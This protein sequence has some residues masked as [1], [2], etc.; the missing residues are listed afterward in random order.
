MGR[1]YQFGGFRVYVDRRSLLRGNEPVQVAA[2]AFDVLVALIDQ[3]HRVVDKDELI[4]R[5]WPDQIVEEANLTQQIF[6]LRRLL[7]HGSFITTVP[8]RGYQFTMA[9]DEW[10]EA[11]SRP[12]GSVAPL[13]RLDLVL[14]PPL[15]LGLNP[16]LVLSR[17]GHVLVYVGA[18]A[19]GTGLHV[20]RLDQH[21]SRPVAGTDGASAPFL[22]PDG[23]WVGYSGEGH[24]HRISIDG[25]RA[26]TICDV[27]GE[28][29]GATWGP[30]NAIVFA[31]APAGPL[32]V[33]AAAGGTARPLTR[34][35]YE[36]G[37][38]SHRFPSFAPDGR[39]VLF[40]IARAGDASFDDATLAIASL[41]SGEHRAVLA[42]GSC[43]TVSGESVLRFQRGGM[44]FRAPFDV[45]A[46]Q[47]LASPEPGEPIA[48]H[49]AGAAHV[50]IADSGL[51]VFAPPA[52]DTS[53]P[54]LIWRIDE[55]EAIALD[56]LA[57][58]P[59]EP[60]V[61]P[62]GSRLV[63]GIR[64]GQSDLWLFDIRRKTLSRLTESGDNFAA[65]WSPDGRSIVFSSNRRG[66]SNL[67]GLAVGSPDPP[68]LLVEDACEL[69]PGA[70][71]PDGRT[72]VYTAYDPHTGADIWA[73]RD[74]QAEVLIK[75]RFNV[76][77]PALS[78]DGRWLAYTSDA[79]GDS[80]VYMIR[81]P[82]LTDRQQVSTGGASE[83]VWDR[84]APRLF[85]RTRT[86]LAYVE[87][88]SDGP[89]RPPLDL[90]ADQ[91]V[92]GSL[93]GLPNYDVHPDGRLLFV[94]PAERPMTRA[95]VR[96]VVPPGPGA[97]DRET[98]SP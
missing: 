2:R 80:E 82:Q 96:V 85:F 72:L 45:D 34:L 89:A 55:G 61:S 67:Y 56:D 63:L 43:G 75:S 7:G 90:I 73:L 66:P 46:V 11:P 21:A 69:V 12:V 10:V 15:V 22:S 93:T 71:T 78:P 49:D 27:E 40:T 30:D 60:R 19:A 6:V 3:R 74:G 97:R 47:C 32:Y 98:R 95:L 41:H 77:S 35:A 86:N 9:V 94:A 57:G 36:D 50:A 31:P 68:V 83:P 4:G 48:I 54:R 58:T 24:L 52:A 8:R 59:E 76:F 26:L 39:S 17:D 87:L 13:L 70:W 29:R 51:L 38:R 1:V 18:S 33:V 91:F 5:V 37:E 79:S 88:G 53:R 42:R 16:A 65:I 44:L 92:R 64:V 28:G 25:G 20:R 14:D 23:R 84:S 62:D 81:F